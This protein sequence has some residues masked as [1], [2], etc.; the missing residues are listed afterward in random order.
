MVMIS[1]RLEAIASQIPPGSRLADIGSDHAL[2]PV[3]AIQRGLADRAVAGELNLG[4]FQAALKQVG[5]AG[6]TGC[7]EVRRG[8]GL[9]VLQQG[10]ADVIVIAGMGGSLIADILEE[11]LAK[12]EGVQKL[13]LQPNVGED[14]VRRFLLAHDWF[15]EKE[16][17]LE[18]DG[19]IYEILAAVR[20]EVQER[21]RE[22]YRP[23]TLGAVG[24][25][26]KELV[27]A[28]AG[29]KVQVT[30]EMLLSMGP[31]LLESGSSVFKRKW[32]GELVKLD[33]ICRE[34]SRS[35]LE[36]AAA[37]RQEMENRR[38]SIEEVLH[39]LPKDKP[40]SN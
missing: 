13:I 39:C 24:S 37:K 40:L 20:E 22:L 33:R 35:D 5:E 30:E 23:R 2:L 21:N 36:E 26:G 1:R 25:D 38:K 18:E 7:I 19:K 29:G 6:L 27:K 10:E 16:T 8:N 17:I 32:E 14:R 9:A 28:S 31:Y 3:Y 11:G 4:P 12:L 34:L 15:L